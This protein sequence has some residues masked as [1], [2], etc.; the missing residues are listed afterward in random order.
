MSISKRLSA[1]FQPDFKQPTVIPSSTLKHLQDYAYR[2]TTKQKHHTGTYHA[3]DRHRIVAL[4]GYLTLGKSPEYIQGQ[5]EADEYRVSSKVPAESWN[6][7]QRR[8]T[9][10]SGRHL[11]PARSSRRNGQAGT[12]RGC[13]GSCPST[14]PESRTRHTRRTA[15]SRFELWQKA[16]PDWRSQKSHITVS[17]ACLKKA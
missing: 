2:E 7:C 16:K 11:G 5:A 15:S 1:S 17:T 12:G 13:P 4:I 8:P 10:P 9:H 14:A 3:G 6:S